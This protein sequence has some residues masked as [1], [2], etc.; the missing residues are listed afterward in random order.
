MKNEAVKLARIIVDTFG[1]CWVEQ[2][3]E[4]NKAGKFAN[5][6]TEIFFR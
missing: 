5:T 1:G 6:M 3:V 4:F 2:L